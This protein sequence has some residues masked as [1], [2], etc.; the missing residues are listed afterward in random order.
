MAKMIGLSF[1]KVT[2][3]GRVIGNPV[4]NGGWATLTLRTIVPEPAPQGG[5]WIE[6][7]IDVPLM[8]N[9][10]KRIDTIQKFVADERQ[11]Y[12]EGYI[13]YWDAN[14]VMQ[15]S[16]VV[17]MIKLGAKTMWDSDTPAGGQPAVPGLQ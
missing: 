3:F 12:V 8:T 2:L 14:G 4:I 9:D 7:E 5:K 16:V 17:T 11:L 13:K 6:T 1:N 10:Q 15:S